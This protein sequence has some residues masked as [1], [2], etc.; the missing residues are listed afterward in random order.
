MVKAV[1]PPIRR[2]SSTSSQF[3]KAKRGHG[4]SSM[5]FTPSSLV[6]GT[7]L[8][9]CVYRV[10]VDEAMECEESELLLDTG[11]AGLRYLPLPRSGVI[12]AS[13]VSWRVEVFVF[14]SGEGMGKQVL[15]LSFLIVLKM[16]KKTPTSS[17]LMQTVT[18]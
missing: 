3:R 10:S 17:M 18:V 11:R 13:M 2:C 12:W 6:P 9:R 4:L 8:S 14:F 16:R 15:L 5:G 1:V 7:E